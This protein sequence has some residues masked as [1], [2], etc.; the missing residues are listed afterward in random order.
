MRFVLVDRLVRVAP[1]EDATAQVT[2]DPSWDVFADHFPGAPIVPGVLLTEAMGQAAGWLIAAT[3]RFV[4]WP[5]LVMIERAKFRR[6]VR[7]G[8]CV[9]LHA[10]IRSASGVAYAVDAHATVGDARVCEAGLAFRLVQPG[11]LGGDAARF[12]AWARETASR[13]G[14]P[15]DTSA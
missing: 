9:T 11:D 3:E 2:F 15:M 5:V 14:L 8:E 12:A 13:L 7:P 4:R 6:L 10:R 1:G